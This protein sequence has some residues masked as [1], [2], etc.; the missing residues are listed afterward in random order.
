MGYNIKVEKGDKGNAKSVKWVFEKQ[1]K[2]E[3]AFSGSYFLRSSR[4]DLKEEEL[5]NLYIIL[6]NV[7]DAFKT[8]KWELNL[9]PVYHQKE[10][11]TDSHI[12]IT[13]IAYHILNAIRTELHSAGIR[14]K[15]KTIRQLL[16]NQVRITTS[17]TTKNSKRI[18]IR[19]TSE[20]EPFQRKIYRA[21]NIKA[22]PLGRKKIIM[23]NL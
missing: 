17:M 4:T 21:L 9:R 2:A 16:S 6:T 19:D 15:W 14:M 1:A 13:V 20:A 12:F 3:E 5:W 23:K 7:E 22:K 8:L 10:N 18:F 11:R